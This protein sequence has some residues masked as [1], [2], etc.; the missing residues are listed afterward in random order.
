MTE[1]KQLAIQS[2]T[3]GSRIFCLSVHWKAKYPTSIEIIGAI[4]WDGRA[5]TNDDSGHGS[6]AL[7]EDDFDFW[8]YADEMVGI[9]PETFKDMEKS[10]L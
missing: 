1:W 6:Y 2:P 8:C 9:F 7:T 4:W 3:N 10:S 5:E